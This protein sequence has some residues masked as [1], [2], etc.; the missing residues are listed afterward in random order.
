VWSALEELAGGGFQE[1]VLTGID[2]AQ[3]GKDLG[4]GESLAGLL[5]RLSRGNWPCRWRLS[6]LEPQ[7]I[8]A[9]LTAALAALPN[10]CP[11]FHLP[12]QSGSPAVLKAMQRPYL[13]GQ[14]LDLAMEL[15]RLF[16]QA[17]LGLDVLVGHPGE[18]AADFEATQA[19]VEALPVA[20]LHVFPFSPRPGTQAHGL[21]PLPGQEVLRRAQVMRQLGQAKKAAFGR[22]Q[23]GQ[24]GEVLI[25]GP[26]PGRPGWLKGL[27]GNYLR[28]VLPGPPAW[29]NRMVRVRFLEVKEEILV[30]EVIALETR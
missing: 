8:T 5:G 14:F 3:Y 18:T 1:V 27:S 9:E 20:Y 6:S 26:A 21:P 16:P 13:P 10:L 15:H 17:A 30:G 7:E 23:V 12:L 4:S 11:H 24:L 2:L 19:L 29:R 25:E 22:A 28:V